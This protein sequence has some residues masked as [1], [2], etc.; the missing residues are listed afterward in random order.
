MNLKKALATSLAFVMGATVL[1]GCG[2]SDKKLGEKEKG[3]RTEI[4]FIC[5][6]NRTSKAAWDALIAAYND[7]AGYETDNV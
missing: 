7:G 3:D 2:S 1:T 4:T 5:D 6:E